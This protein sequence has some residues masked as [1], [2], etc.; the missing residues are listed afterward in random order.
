MVYLVTYDLHKV[1]R[2]YQPV[3][4]LLNKNGAVHPMGSV[5]L[6]DSSFS[7]HEWRNALRDAVDGNDEILVVQ[8]HRDEWASFNLDSSAASWLES[9]ARSW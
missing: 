4:D 6:V 3:F 9:P 1:G 2:N 5:W 7:R 8:L